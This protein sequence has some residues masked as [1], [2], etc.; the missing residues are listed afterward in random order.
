[1]AQRFLDRA[2]SHKYIELNSHEPYPQDM[3]ST[4]VDTTELWTNYVGKEIKQVG[5]R[6]LT[7]LPPLPQDPFCT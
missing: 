3:K 6:Y 7:S 5:G 1:M 4:W 2:C